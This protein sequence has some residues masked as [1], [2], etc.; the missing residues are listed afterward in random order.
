M[1]AWAVGE[2]RAQ[3]EALPGVARSD[4]TPN[5]SAKGETTWWALR[6]H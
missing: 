4:S 5:G 2:W 3:G 6:N 1:Q